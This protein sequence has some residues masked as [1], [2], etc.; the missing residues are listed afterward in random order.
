MM[1]RREFVAFLGGAVAT[2]P[3]TARAQQGG[4]T[5][6]IGVLMGV[7]EADPQ[8][9][10]RLAAF[11]KRLQELGWSEDRNI[12]IAIR[13]VGESAEH[14]RA[15]VADL[16]AMTPS[17]IVADTTAVLSALRPAAG[18]IPIVFLRVSDPV[19]SGF[20]ES[21]AR[22]GGNITGVANFEYAI[23]GKWL[24]L[25]KQVAPWMRQVAV[26]TNPGMTAHEG[27]RRAIEEAGPSFAVAIR[28]LPA[29]DT[30]EIER[31]ILAAAG[32]PASG[33]I[34]LPH[35]VIE[36]NRGLIIAM[37]AQRRIPAI[38][39]LR[40]YTS[41]GGL[42]AYGPEPRALYRQAAALVDRVL[43]G[44]KPAEVP[45]QQPA[46]FELSINLKTANA[47][48][49]TLPATLLALADEVIE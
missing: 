22:P 30:A 33:L 10:P 45:V 25:L 15:G 24:E 44:A 23:G 12:Q 5:P 40:H 18:S 2:W 9:R 27:L 13:W 42:I 37:A 3:F 34:L 20:V 16:V 6:R 21:L 4:R 39:S 11:R 41:A 47:L 32:E 17:L 48:G 28:A 29:R 8:A 49:L 31:A 46:N 14:L 7:A 19:N 36:S 38:Y 1:R 35:L 26:L 43:R